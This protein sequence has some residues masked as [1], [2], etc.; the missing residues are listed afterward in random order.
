MDRISTILVPFDFSNIAK[1]A[2]EYTAAFV[3]RN[4]DIKIVLAHISGNSNFSILPENLKKIE[5]KYNSKLKNKLEWVT[6]SGSLTDA[7]LSIQKTR[8]VDMV[9]MG[10]SG[11]Q[12]E[13]DAEMTNTSKFVLEADCPVLVVPNGYKEFKLKR[14]ALVL[15]NEEIE[16]THVLG[17]LLQVARRFN[18]QVHV[19]TVENKPGNYGY[20]KEEE[21]NENAVE[22]YLESFYAE[23]VFIKNKDV[24]EGILDYATKKEL[25]L[26]TIL[27]RNHSKRS[28][29]SEGQLTQLLTVHSQVPLLAID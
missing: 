26:I 16:D 5:E 23:R 11:T 25:D 17:R 14:I 18:A 24:V 7:L 3:G 27:P 28:E 21:K 6:Q 20:S 1:S 2:L 4:D 9:I 15:G 29:P 12:K 8:Q 19:V 22:Y 13:G 10:T